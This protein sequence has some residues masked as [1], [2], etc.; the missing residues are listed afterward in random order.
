M[1]RSASGRNGWEADASTRFECDAY[2]GDDTWMKA[3]VVCALLLLAS[4]KDQ[5]PKPQ[6]VIARLEAGNLSHDDLQKVRNTFPGMTQA[7]AEKVRAGGLKAMPQRTEDCFEMTPRQ[8]W[9]GLWRADLEGSQFCAD[10]PGKPATECVGQT[11]RPETWFEPRARYDADGSL[12]HVE[13]IGRRTAQPGRFGSYGTFQH[14]MIVDRM[15]SILKLPPR[16]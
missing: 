7:C 8:H 2:S 5:P 16:G 9:S 12:Y 13:F 1:R 6:T 4:C 11:S 14:E 15:I 10:A 3:A